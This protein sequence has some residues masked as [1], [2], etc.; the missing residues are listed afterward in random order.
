MG[1][2]GLSFFFNNSSQICI[3][4]M[5]LPSDLAEIQTVS[6]NLYFLSCTKVSNKF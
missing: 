2:R 4:F 6:I 3:K 1:Q 5:R